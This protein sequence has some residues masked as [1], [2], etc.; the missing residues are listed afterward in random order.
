MDGILILWEQ[1]FVF[2]FSVLLYNTSMWVHH[3]KGFSP[4]MRVLA[5]SLSVAAS[6]ESGH[7]LKVIFSFVSTLGLENAVWR[8]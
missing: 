5:T 6:P 4:A 2:C 3:S 1:T 8:F 7:L